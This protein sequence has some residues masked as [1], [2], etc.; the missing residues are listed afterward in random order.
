MFRFL[1]FYLFIF[2]RL[3]SYP[4]DKIISPSLAVDEEPF[5][6]GS[7]EPQCVPCT[8]KLDNTEVELQSEHSETKWT[9]CQ[10]PTLINSKL[11][12]SDW[13]M[14]YQQVR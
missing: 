10:L 5:P 8:P 1:S 9:L 7:T 13:F 2:S 11:T 14:D 3:P 12:T 4:R 6:L